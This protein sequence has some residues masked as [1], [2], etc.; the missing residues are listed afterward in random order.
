MTVPRSRTAA[1]TDSEGRSRDKSLPILSAGQ[2]VSAPVP[3][4]LPSFVPSE[5]PEAYEAELEAL[6]QH[7][8]EHCWER[9]GRPLRA[10]LD[11][12]LSIS[13]PSCAG[14]PPPGVPVS[15]STSS[16]AERPGVPVKTLRELRRALVSIAGD[17][18]VKHADL[19]EYKSGSLLGWHQ[20]SF[21]WKRHLCT[22]VVELA[23]RR[24]RADEEGAI[25]CCVVEGG[26]GRGRGTNAP[27]VWSGNIRGA[28]PE[29]GSGVGKAS[30]RP[31]GW[32]RAPAVELERTTTSAPA[33]DEGTSPVGKFPRQEWCPIVRH[34]E[35][36]SIG[37]REDE[38]AGTEGAVNMPDERGP[39]LDESRRFA[40]TGGA[41]A[42]HGVR[43]NWEWAHRGICEAGSRICIVMFCHS[44]KMAQIARESG[45]PIQI[46][47]AKWWKPEMNELRSLSSSSDH[48][49]SGSGG[50]GAE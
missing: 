7:Y 29:R 23:C 8:P 9:A 44:E 39:W 30:A 48:K 43:C 33:G 45:T 22:V 21:D 42:C 5:P 36:G 49:I 2:V 15:T 10:N 28:N 46:D 11:P 25:S 50:V 12:F 18:Q 34:A 1:L 13:T 47:M 16:C 32:V 3:L 17:L 14:Q 24:G 4:L 35:A 20:D 38:N 31:A 26:S 27:A 19:L 6:K 40:V 37:K 41:L